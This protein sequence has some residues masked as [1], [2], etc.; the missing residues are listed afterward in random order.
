MD[1]HIQ[2]RWMLLATVAIG[3]ILMYLF[4]S[5]T[6]QHRGVWLRDHLMKSLH[7]CRDALANAWQDVHNQARDIF[8]EAKMWLRR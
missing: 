5:F 7:R 1:W 2:D 4:N 3:A 8:T 6:G